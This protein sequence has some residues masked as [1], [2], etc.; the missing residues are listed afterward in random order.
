M[1][2]KKPR[3]R[4]FDSRPLGRLRLLPVEARHVSEQ[5]PIVT[6]YVVVTYGVSE[7]VLAGMAASEG[8]QS[9]PVKD[10]SVLI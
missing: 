7:T 6:R 8:W 5:A 2:H 4:P 9:E 1:P 3:N 10:V